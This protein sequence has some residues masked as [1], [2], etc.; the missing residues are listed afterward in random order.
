[1]ENGMVLVLSLW[2][3]H[4]AG[5]LWLD[6]N[7]PADAVSIS[8]LYQSIQIMYIMMI[9]LCINLMLAPFSHLVFKKF[10]N[11]FYLPDYACIPV[12]IYSIVYI[13]FLSSSH[14]ITCT[15][16]LIKLTFELYQDPSKPGVSRGSCSTD[17]GKRTNLL[18]KSSA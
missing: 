2:D 16:L 12:H 8:F 7:F 3:D 10:L 14:Y 5:M 1:M 4:E 6:S 13:Y 15:Q 9:L 11:I 17:S 18:V